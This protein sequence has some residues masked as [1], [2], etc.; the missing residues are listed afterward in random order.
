MTDLE[1]S[2]FTFFEKFVD[3]AFLY[4]DQLNILLQIKI[5]EYI[6]ELNAVKCPIYKDHNNNVWGK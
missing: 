1:V 2:N 3:Q 6:S 4:F 5:I